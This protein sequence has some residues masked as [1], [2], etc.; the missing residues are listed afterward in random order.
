MLLIYI[1]I[2]SKILPFASLSCATKHHQR[3]HHHHIHFFLERNNFTVAWHSSLGISPGGTQSYTKRQTFLDGPKY[4]HLFELTIIKCPSFADGNYTGMQKAM[5]PLSCNY[6]LSPSLI[7]SGCA[8]RG[9]PIGSARFLR[10]DNLSFI[11]AFKA[12]AKSESS[13]RSEVL[14]IY[15]SSPPALSIFLQGMFETNN[16]GMKR[17]AQH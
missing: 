11:S 12:S 6:Q 2:C 5:L 14:R 7:A 8:A 9:T 3:W 1:Y 15:W 16:N 17:H 4:D 13:L 10:K